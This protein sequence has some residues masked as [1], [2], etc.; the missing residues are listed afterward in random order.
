MGRRRLQRS[1]EWDGDKER[2]NERAKTIKKEKIDKIYSSDLKRTI[3]TA[4]IIGRERKQVIKFTPLIREISDETI[5][6]HK[7]EWENKEF[8][9]KRLNEIKEFLRKLEKKHKKEMREHEK[10][11]EDNKEIGKRSKLPYEWLQSNGLLC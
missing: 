2:E 3:Q 10:K 1:I 7:N 8:N 6:K 5:E 11:L 9:N 4:K